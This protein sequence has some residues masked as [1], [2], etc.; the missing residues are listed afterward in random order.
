MLQSWFWRKSRF[1]KYW[2]IKKVCPDA[3]KWTNIQNNYI[4]I[5]N[6]LFDSLIICSNLYWW[7]DT[8]DND[9]TNKLPKGDTYRLPTDDTYILP[10][11]DTY[12]LPTDDACK[13]PKGDIYRLPTDDTYI[14]PTDDTYILPADD[15]YKLPI[16]NIYRLPTDDIYRLPTDDT[17][18]NETFSKKMT[19]YEPLKHRINYLKCV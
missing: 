9:D 15:T 2:E 16:G 4:L 18:V 6:I 11:D 13:L 8:D 7:S 1:P 12:I 19:T 14:L 10:T 5:K 3:F 17:Y